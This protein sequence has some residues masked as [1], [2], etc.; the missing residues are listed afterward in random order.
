MNEDLFDKL[1]I[2]DKEYKGIVDYV[3]K[4]QVMFYDFTNSDSCAITLLIILWKTT[5]PNERFS[6]FQ[7][8]NF[9]HVNIGNVSVLNRKN[10]RIKGRKLSTD[11]TQIESSRIKSSPSKD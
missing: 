2:D 11:E 10:I 5:D 8:K 3:S 9:P 6:I 4:K 1:I 7:A